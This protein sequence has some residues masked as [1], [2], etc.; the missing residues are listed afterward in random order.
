MILGFLYFGKMQTHALML[1][2]VHLTPLIFEM[3]HIDL[4]YFKNV[5]YDYI[6][7]LNIQ[8]FKDLGGLAHGLKIRG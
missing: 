4:E 7:G 1:F 2:Y 6:W 3:V 5:H 8:F